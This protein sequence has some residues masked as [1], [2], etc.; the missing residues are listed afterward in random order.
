[1]NPLA[2][3][4]RNWSL[5]GGAQMLASLV[6]MVFMV[7]VSRQLGAVEF[8]RLY[9]A[10]T[11]ASIVAVLG[12]AGLSQVLIRSVARDR[13][14]LGPYLA[15]SAALIAGSAAAL[16]AILLAAS[17]ALGFTPEVD[18]LVAV[19]GV[20][21]VTEGIAQLLGGAFQGHERMVVP[22]LAR[23]GSNV[24]TL[25]VVVPL[26]LVWRSPLVV[27]G[28][29]VL[30][31]LLRV[32]V[33]ALSIGRLEGFRLSPPPAPPWPDLLRAGLPFLA[34]QGLGVFVVRVDVVMLGRLASEA[35][36]GWY[37][38]ASRTVEALYVIPTMLTSATFPV[39][40]RLWGE[41]AGPFQAT[42][43]KTLQVVLVISIPVAATLFVL[44]QD[45]VSF[46]F[47]LG[48]FAPAVPILRIQALTVP[49]VFVDYLLVCGLMAVGRERIWLA[50]VVAACFLD[51]ALDW[52]LIRAA[53]AAYSNGGIGAALATLLTEIFLF[54]CVFRALPAGVLDGASLRVAARAALVGGLQG[55]ALVAFRVVGVPWVAAA[56]LAGCLYVLAVIRLRLLPPDVVGWLGELIRRRSPRLVPARADAVPA[57]PP[58]ADAA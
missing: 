6:A 50:I 16:Y 47:T 27:A 15:R 10:F 33:Q 34:A 22:A 30:G 24:V 42:L 29:L 13:A 56:A 58:S 19:L 43:R 14:T 45:I 21:I 48:A 40:S 49:L 12:D 41:G 44:A 38:A 7:V 17:H 52:V 28:V 36:V 54:A 57:D 4:L 53:D 8:G 35:A 26:L 32:A 39:L 20:L 25:A 18:A 46:L 3:I 23:V 5:L 31:S 37:G 1:M 9:L 55:A 11:L 51:P 2:S